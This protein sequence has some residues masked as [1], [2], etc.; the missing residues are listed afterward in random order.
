VITY[1]DE[2][3]STHKLLIQ[4][5]KNRSLKPPIALSAEIQNSG[6]G[7]RDN[8]WQGFNGNL[9]LSFCQKIDDLP[10]DLPQQSISI[11]YSYIIKSVLEDLG[12]NLFLKWP[13]DFYI[14]EKKIG[15]T[16]TKIIDNEIV[17]CS[18]G[19]NLKKAPEDFEIIDINIDK[20]QLLKL[21][22]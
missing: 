17:V 1:L 3:T 22:F 19:I 5:L 21:F 15:G 10:S 14:G 4:S 8:S 20:K 9:F 18:I 2:V 13:N 16:I 6:V 11:Y 7:S 12:S